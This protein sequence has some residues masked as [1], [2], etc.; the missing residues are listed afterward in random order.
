MYVHLYEIMKVTVHVVVVFLYMY[1]Y[2]CMMCSTGG[3]QERL[4][5]RGTDLK[6][7][8][9][10]VCPLYKGLPQVSSRSERERERERT[11]LYATASYCTSTCFRVLPM[12]RYTCVKVATRTK[13]RV[14]RK[15][16]YA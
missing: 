10:S 3:L 15:S 4:S 7:R 1:M 2:V 5:Q 9:K 11:P 13:L 6:S 14:S 12:M 16:R 8:G